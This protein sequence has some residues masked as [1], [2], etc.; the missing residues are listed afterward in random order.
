MLKYSEVKPQLVKLTSQ[1]ACQLESIA[2]FPVQ[3]LAIAL[4]KAAEDGPNT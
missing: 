1:L 4:G 3:L 2:L